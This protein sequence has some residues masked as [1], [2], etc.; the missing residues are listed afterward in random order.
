MNRGRQQPDASRGFHRNARGGGE[1]TTPIRRCRP[2]SAH[3]PPPAPNAPFSAS[4]CSSAQV[5]VVDVKALKRLALSFERK[6]K[7]NTESRM[8]ARAAS[9]GR[10]D[11][12]P[13]PPSSAHACTLRTPAGPRGPGP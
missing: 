1:K 7:E 4:H 2:S 8:K 3:P 6:L 12:R 5:E 10:W 11:S 9:V 13:H